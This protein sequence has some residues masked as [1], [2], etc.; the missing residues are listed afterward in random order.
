M[1]RLW[2][3]W[4]PIILFALSAAPIRAADEPNVMVFRYHEADS[5]SDQRD[6]YNW[7]VLAA[8]LER[9]RA[10]YGDYRLVPSTRQAGFRQ[11]DGVLGGNDVRNVTVLAGRPGAADEVIGVRIPVDRGLIGYRVLLIRDADQRRFARIEN[12][13]DLSRISIGQLDSW[14]VTKIL[15]ADGMN[16]VTGESYEGLF[17]MLM[18]RR[19]D[20]FSRGVGEIG[21]EYD[22]H[23][24]EYPGLAIEKTLLLHIPMA[25][26]FWFP[27]DEE[28]RR[29]AERVRIGLQAMI[30][31]GS[32]KTLFDQEFGERLRRLD[33]GGRRVI[34]LPNPVQEHPEF[35]ENSD[36]WFKL[37]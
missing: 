7:R 35:D 20:A 1:A 9:T 8:V 12:R 5:P 11:A 26:Y 25:E 17:K 28:G 22:S 19:F 10:A 27:N 32:L 18:T 37:N 2:K 15:R 14:Q 4:V 33:I 13:R 24:A 21:D 29:H 36:L 34:E 31:D 23:S 3:K 30:S 6:R 16:V